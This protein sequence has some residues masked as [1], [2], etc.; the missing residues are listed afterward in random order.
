MNENITVVTP[1]SIL[2][3][4]GILSNNRTSSRRMKI[5]AE[6][7]EE[8]KIKLLILISRN[9]DMILIFLGNQNKIT[10]PYF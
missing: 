10:D 4:N 9:K 5:L 3:P 8:I 1:N 2:T 7:V 6:E